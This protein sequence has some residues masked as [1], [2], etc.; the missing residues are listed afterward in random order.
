[1]QMKA[2]ESEDE[3][4][5]MGDSQDYRDDSL[6]F[7]KEARKYQKNHKTKRMG[8][9]EEFKMDHEDDSIRF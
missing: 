9:E 4:E 7:A 3:S 5:L 2:Q 1:M 8:Q 6:S